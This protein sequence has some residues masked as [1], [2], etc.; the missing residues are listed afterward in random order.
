MKS[1]WYEYKPEARRLRKKGWSIKAIRK[2]LGIPLSTLSGWLRDIE[3]SKK[4][5]AKLKKKWQQALVDARAKAV[6]WHNEQKRL[7]LEQAEIQA[8]IVLS[9]IEIADKNILDLTLALLYLGEGF[10]GSETGIGNSDPLILRFFLAI[11]KENYDVDIKN[12]TCEL[13]LR[14]DQDADKVKKFWAKKLQIP[15]S[16]FKRA[17]FDQR[18]LGSKTYSHYKGVCLMRIGNVAIQRKL[19]YLSNLYCRQVI[20]RYLGD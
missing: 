12:I 19:V 9:K 7:R 14:A 4:Q 5:Q 10:K 1:N 2:E 20:S 8:K 6:L 3:L 18:T 13:H 11:L 16:N 15:I 17:Y